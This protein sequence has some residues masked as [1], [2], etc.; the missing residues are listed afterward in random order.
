MSLKNFSWVVPSKLSGSSMPKCTGEESDI[1]WLA[2][3]GVRTLVSLTLPQGPVEEICGRSGLAWIYFPIPDFGVPRK[4]DEFASLVE[5][6]VTSIQSEKPVCVHC[7]AG[8]GRTGLVLSCVLGKLFSLSPWSAISA[9]RK[10]RPAIETS[11]Q[12]NFIQQFLRDYEN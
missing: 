9:V 10:V 6:L 12:E 11:E 4:S 2:D 3:Q 1:E 8:I 7:H 5:E